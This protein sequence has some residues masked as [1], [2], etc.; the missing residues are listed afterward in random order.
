MIRAVIFD[1]DG[2]LL[3]S[4]VYWERARRGYAATHGCD[5][6]KQDELAVKGMNSPE[7]AAEIRHHC[8]PDMPVDTIIHGVTAR[9]RHLYAAQLPLLPGA[10]RAVDSLAPTYPLGVASSSPRTLIEDV[11]RD[12]G[13]RGAFEVIVS[14]DEV[15]AGK[16]APAVFLA[17]AERMRCAPDQIAVF[18]DSSAGILAAHRAGMHVIAV[19]NR[20]YP[21][22][23][24]ALSLA[25]LVLPSLEAFT[26]D[27]LQRM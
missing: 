17:T 14:S 10:R 3:D 9:M 7:W 4:E 18:E 15:S 12:A 25:D 22:S 24:E 11:L 8:G 16:P 21:P 5:W 19:P 20:H 26:P 23:A 13:L 6:T 1:M 27:V 2:L